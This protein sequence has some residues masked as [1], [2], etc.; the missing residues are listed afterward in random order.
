MRSPKTSLLAIGLAF[1]PA[2]A[3]TTSNLDTFE[4]SPTP[5]GSES[6]NPQSKEYAKL[7]Y[8]KGESRHNLGRIMSWGGL[9]LSVI[10]SLTKVPE[11]SSIGGLALLI[12]IPVNG[13][14]AG[15]MVEAANI[16]N[17]NAGLEISGWGTYKASWLLIG[18]GTALVIGS[19]A[20]AETVEEVN[21]TALGVGL[22]SLVAGQIM[23]YVAWGQFSG[24]ADRAEMIHGL[25]YSVDVMPALYASRT[26]IAT[27]GVQLS[28]KF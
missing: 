22:V 16:L 23:Q 5:A 14:G 8:A 20:G 3:G 21:T 9:G 25:A 12:G 11:M 18:G 17:P 7:L 1:A 26:A 27:P 28:V 13:S 19:V 15:T 6:N 4:T 24:S 2:F 10:G